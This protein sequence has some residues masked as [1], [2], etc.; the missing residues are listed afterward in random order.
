MS[1]QTRV[2]LLRRKISFLLLF[3]VAVFGS[4]RLFHKV[5]DGFAIAAIS[6]DLPY[7][8]NWDVPISEKDLGESEKALGETYSYLT[9]GSQSF[10]CISSQGQYIVKFFKHKRWRI[11]PF[12]DQIPLP[13]YLKMKKE[14][15][16]QKKQKTIRSTFNSCKISYTKL[17]DETGIIFLHLNKTNH[18]NKNLIVR[19]RLGYKH[20]LNL[21]EIA[22]IIQKNATAT[23]QYL[24]ELRK[25]GDLKEAKKSI[26]NLLNFTVQRATEG[27]NDKDPHLIRNFGFINDQVIEIDLGGFY[28][29][30]KKNEDYFFSHEI[31]R[32]RRKLMP[33]IKK[34][35]PELM[36]YVENQIKKIISTRALLTDDP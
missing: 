35:Y 6:S 4:I 24:L 31:Y 18:L 5:T 22:F 34:N 25:K 12:L 29:D 26:R 28:Q 9:S 15:W 14:K 7:N 1:D 2:R 33:W 32:I 16:K 19:D 8:Q 20:K 10:V 21:D 17:H 27:Y 36:D 30:P 3:I 23:D 13:P 11:N